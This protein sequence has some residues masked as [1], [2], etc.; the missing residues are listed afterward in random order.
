MN[1]DMTT[2]WCLYNVDIVASVS[3]L[4]ICD[5]YKAGGDSDDS[6]MSVW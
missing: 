1:V 4:S 5:E 2:D 3:R 6:D